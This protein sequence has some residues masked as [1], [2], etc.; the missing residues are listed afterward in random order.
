MINR[1]NKLNLARQAALSGISRGG[2]SYTPRPAS[3]DNLKPMRP[4]DELHMDD[5]FAG[6]RMMKGLSRH[7]VRP[8]TWLIS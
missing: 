1:C 7:S 3:Q 2:L 4:I 5:R 6:S 8:F